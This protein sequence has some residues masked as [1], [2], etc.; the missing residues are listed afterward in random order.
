MMQQN[1]KDNTRRYDCKVEIAGNAKSSA[2]YPPISP[3]C[4][5]NTFK[6][7]C[8]VFKRF[9]SLNTIF[10]GEEPYVGLILISFKFRMR[11][12]GAD[13]FMKVFRIIVQYFICTH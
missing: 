12:N 8:N 6:K 10:I 7:G 13:I 9:F 4:L 11:L 5:L 2:L 1:G 3:F